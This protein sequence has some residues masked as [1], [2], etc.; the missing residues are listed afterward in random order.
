MAASLASAT[1]SRVESASKHIVPCKM[2]YDYMSDVMPDDR[3]ANVKRMTQDHM[4]YSLNKDDLAIGLGRPAFE[5]QRGHAAKHSAHPSVVACFTDT[6]DWFQQLLAAK[7][8]GE[9]FYT[10]VKL[11]FSRNGH[12][13]DVE[14]FERNLT[15][16]YCVGVSL[17]LACIHPSKG[18]TVASV[19]IGGLK[20]ILNGAFP[21]HTND[22]LMFYWPCEKD[23]FD[24]S[25]QRKAD[26][27]LDPANNAKSSSSE[28]SRQIYHRGKMAKT[29]HG[30]TAGLCVPHIKPYLVKMGADVNSWD[31]SR[32]F[33]KAMSN[34]Q[35]W[36]QVDIMISRQS[37]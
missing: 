35:P 23:Y 1:Q 7:Y 13:S 21:V 8:Q 6:S 32:V 16:M 31:A 5:N 24:A 34:A 12:A 19:M 37:L 33:A 14:K 27:D 22:L 17:G 2:N 36:E 15:H 4:R 29:S 10:L 30:D 18:D 20:T 9:V 3:S 25:G 26:G 11:D 28:N